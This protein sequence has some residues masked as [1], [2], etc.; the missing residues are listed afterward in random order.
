MRAISCKP[1]QLSLEWDLFVLQYLYP[2][3]VRCP[4]YGGNVNELA[5][6][7]G[8]TAIKMTN[9]SLAVTERQY[10]TM[11]LGALSDDTTATAQWDVPEVLWIDFSADGGQ[12]WDN[13]AG[14]VDTQNPD[15]GSFPWTVP[16]QLTEQGVVMVTGYYGDAPT[17]SGTFAIRREAPPDGGPETCV[18]VFTD[19]PD[20]LDFR[21]L[22]A[23]DA[24]RP[25]R[26]LRAPARA[27]VKLAALALPLR[28]SWHTDCPLR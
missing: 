23:A 9:P 8:F 6:E 13:L 5:E 10:G 26:T 27:L 17:Q 22:Q 7:G 1:F 11:T 4:G 28:C 20:P 19:M 18:N 2:N 21:A 25:R 14:S 24:S 16:D 12:N 15:W 3:G